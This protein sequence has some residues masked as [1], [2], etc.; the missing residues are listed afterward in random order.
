MIEY[1][2]ENVREGTIFTRGARIDLAKLEGVGQGFR[3]GKREE[4]KARGDVT[5]FVQAH[6][7][8]FELHLP[9][10]EANWG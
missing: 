4:R 5:C 7:K 2:F 8:A 1:R 9:L 6:Q 10:K 3:E